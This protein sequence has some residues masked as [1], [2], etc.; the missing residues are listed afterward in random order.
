MIRSSEVQLCTTHNRLVEFQVE[1]ELRTQARSND[2]KKEL[3]KA[4][5]G[6]VKQIIL[7]S[8]CEGN[9]YNPKYAEYKALA[10]S[11]INNELNCL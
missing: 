8:V 6:V 2:Q 5:G 7:P 1:K 4:V 9:E 11:I 3:Q 10:M